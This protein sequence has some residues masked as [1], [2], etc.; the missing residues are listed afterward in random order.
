[1]HTFNNPS[2]YFE[3]KISTITNILNKYPDFTKAVFN[4]MSQACDKPFISGAISASN[5]L[6]Q[7]H[8]DFAQNPAN[9]PNDEYSRLINLLKE[10]PVE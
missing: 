4:K 3:D 9:I 7:V 1:M 10:F 6:D 2:S 5:I 8:C